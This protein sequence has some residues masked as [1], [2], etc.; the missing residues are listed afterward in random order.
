LVFPFAARPI[1]VAYPGY[2]V[3]TLRQ[4]E[5]LEFVEAALP[6]VARRRDRVYPPSIV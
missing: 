4:V 2:P 1:A 5:G 3:I 6:A